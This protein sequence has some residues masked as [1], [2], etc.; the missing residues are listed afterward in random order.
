[1]NDFEKKWLEV[2]AHYCR[3]MYNRNARERETWKEAALTYEE[4]VS[5][6]KQF[7]IENFQK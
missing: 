4:Y 5:Q 1:M 6:N 3:D 7:L 2:P